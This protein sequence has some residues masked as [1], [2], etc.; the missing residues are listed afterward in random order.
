MVSTT[1]AATQ[2]IES[3]SRRWRLILT[4]QNGETLDSSDGTVISMN[5]TIEASS[6]TFTIGEIFTQNIN[7]ELR[8]AID[9]DPNITFEYEANAAIRIAYGLRDA[10]GLIHMG[11][12][13]VK[14]VEKVRDRIRLNLK[15]YLINELSDTYTAS[16]FPSYPVPI[17][18]VMQDICSEYMPINYYE[19]LYILDD[20]HEGEYCLAYDNADSIIYVLSDEAT[21]SGGDPI[22]LSQTEIQYLSGKKVS[23]ALS[24][25]AGL[26]GCSLVKGRDNTLECIRPSRVPVE[27][28]SSR[29]AAPDFSGKEQQIVGTICKRNDDVYSEKNFRKWLKDSQQNELPGIYTEFENPLM[30]VSDARFAEITKDYRGWLMR[31]ATI[32]HM[33]GDPRLDPLDIVGYEDI[34]DEMYEESGSYQMPL[35]SLSYTFDGGLSCT[36]R[37]TANY[38]YKEENNG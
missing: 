31:P 15:D 1:I 12:F 6:D 5:H 21:D 16:T 13:R 29:S 4:D 37:S 17:L 33:L 32:N 36:L 14:K 23:E 19:P 38:S 35:M 27:I 30:N 26:L 34:Y 22:T 3:D 25:C 7:I 20:E 8:R 28:T 2:K 10:P 24:I 18:D 9:Q 11:T